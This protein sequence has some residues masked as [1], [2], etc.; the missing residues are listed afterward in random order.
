[1][2]KPNA[3]ALQNR[4][5]DEF[6]QLHGGYGYMTEYQIGRAWTDA[7]IG[8]G[9]A[10]LV[11]GHVAVAAVQLQEFVEQA[12]LQRRGIGLDHGGAG[13]EIGRGSWRGRG[14]ISVVGGSFK[15]K[16]ENLVG[17][18]VRA[19]TGNIV[20]HDPKSEAAGTTLEVMA[21][22]TFGTATPVATNLQNP[23]GLSACPTD[24]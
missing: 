18:L 17:A 19:L 20:S 4:L 22:A 11:F 1:M 9:A 3:T 23:Q 7:R 24:R 16:K 13:G 8:P 10:D 5:L 12:V 14:E 21:V 15:K 6:L 2:V